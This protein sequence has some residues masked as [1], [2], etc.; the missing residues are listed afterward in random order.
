VACH[1][2]NPR[3]GFDPDAGTYAT[4]WSELDVSCE[5]CHGPG[6][7]HLEIVE[8]RSGDVDPDAEGWGLPGPLPRGD[9]AWTIEPG[10]T[11]ASRSADRDDREVETCAPCHSRRAK[12]AEVPAGRADVLDAYRVSLLRDGL[13]HA[14]GQ[15]L[16]EVYVYGSFLQSR[17]YR[18]GVTCSDCHDPHGLEL[19]ADGNALCTRCHLESAYDAPSHTLHDRASEGGRCVECHMPATT[20]M[21][22]D[23]R[24]DHSLRIPRPD[25]SATVGVPNACDHCHADRPAEWAARALDGRIPDRDASQARFAT[26]VA[27]GRRGDPAAA[28]ELARMAGDTALAPIRRA[29]ALS[30]LATQAPSR[31]GDAIARGLRDPEPLVRIGAIQALEA[32]PAAS[33]EALAAPL[34]DDPVAAVASEAAGALVRS[35]ATPAGPDREAPYARADA[36]WSRVQ[37]LNTD[38]SSAWVNLG[39]LHAARGR[40]VEAEAAYRKALDLDPADR[41]AYVN[42]ADLQRALGRDDL[43]E[44]TLGGALAILPEAPELQHATG[45][46]RIRQGRMDEALELLG[47]AAAGRPADARF[48][49]VYAVAL[50][51]SGDRQNALEEL[52]RG[53]TQH[54]YDRDLLAALTAYSLEI[55]RRDEALTWA[56]RLLEVAP[57]DAT[58]RLLLRRNGAGP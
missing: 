44:R 19:R 21:G 42:L 46:L 7:R 5:A 11:T 1:S 31:T 15:I 34:L 3:K 30:L 39:D 6:S 37:R 36:I 43:A 23:A 18:A 45:L 17:M 12:V 8:A 50:W 38:H 52:R 33:V 54:P 25:L 14:D 4:T 51:S 58:A 53:V 41:S 24:R 40:A 57:D 2:T 20:Y 13:Y 55:G 56:R 47:R 22:V 27:A 35:G 26:A 49:Y 28:G 9:F 10:S 29:T 32:L 16:D 48:A